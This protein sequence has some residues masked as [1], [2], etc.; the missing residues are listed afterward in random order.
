MKWDATE[1]S[2]GTFTYS[3]ADA[4]VS[5]ALGNG[6]QLRGHTLGIESSNTLPSPPNPLTSLAPATSSLG[7][8]R[9]L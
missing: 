6:Q 5:F 9:Q 2:Q 3:D 8:L 4:I 1:P 7:N